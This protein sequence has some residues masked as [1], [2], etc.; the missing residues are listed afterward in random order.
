MNESHQEMD[1]FANHFTSLLPI[2]SLLII[3]IKVVVHY[4]RIRSFYLTLQ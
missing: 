4:V 3:Q 2:I 1:G